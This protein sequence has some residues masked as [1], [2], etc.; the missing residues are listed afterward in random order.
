MRDAFPG[1][2]RPT[3]EEFDRLWREGWFV[4]DANV[5]LNLYRYE[6]DTRDDLLR[7]IRKLQ[8]RIW[9]PYQAALEYHRNRLT[10][11]ADQD[12]KFM[13]M[14][15]QVNFAAFRNVV[16]SQNDEMRSIIDPDAFLAAV[17]PHF[18]DF[19]KR[20]ADLRAKQIAVGGDDPVRTELDDIL[21]NLGSPLTQAELDDLYVEGERRYKLKTPPGYEDKKEGSYEYAGRTYRRAFGD[22]I[23]WREAL[24]WA[25][26]RTI[27][28]VIFVTDDRKQ[29][30]WLLD[31]STKPNQR[32]GPRPELAAEMRQVAGVELFYLYEPAGFL[33]FAKTVLGADV[34]DT[35]IA[36]V[37]EVSEEDELREQ[38]IVFN[39]EAGTDFDIGAFQFPVFINGDRHWC[40]IAKETVSDY[41]NLGADAGHV[42]EWETFVKNRRTINAAA[43][44][45]IRNMNIGPDGR[46]RIGTKELAT[47]NWVSRHRTLCQRARIL[48]EQAKELSTKL[49]QSTAGF[50]RPTGDDL[51]S[52][53]AE[54]SAAYAAIVEIRSGVPETVDSVEWERTRIE[55]GRTG[56]DIFER[57]GD[58]INDLIQEKRRHGRGDF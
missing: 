53:I 6:A 51:A 49:G 41:F 37:R 34:R 19:E 11:I 30:W 8:D 52:L 14:A 42:E 18:S 43:R 28:C 4:F 55:D 21:N 57:L 5:L 27:K 20:L 58:L 47:T 15:K 3:K 29:D 23:L 38:T 45:A 48:V 40:V 22:W 10:V 46:I 36:E 31:T 25:K 2:Y 39:D 16:M 9:I 54:V 50:G 13:D 1:F 44:E 17:E 26:S 35:S 32:I 7:V 33:K 56:E 12:R 24:T